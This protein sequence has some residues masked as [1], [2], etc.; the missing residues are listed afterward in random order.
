[1]PGVRGEYTGHARR[2]LADRR[3]D[4]L[5]MDVAQPFAWIKNP[6]RNEIGGMQAR[7]PGLRR[8]RQKNPRNCG[9][10]R[11][12]GVSTPGKIGEARIAGEVVA[13]DRRAQPFVLRPR[14]PA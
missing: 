11:I 8:L 10:Q 1:M 6:L 3:L 13:A 12:H 5:D 4:G 14:S 7:K 2:L 9:I